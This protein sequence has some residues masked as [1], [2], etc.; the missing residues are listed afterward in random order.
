MDYKTL[1]GNFGNRSYN[2]YY[3]SGI[4][5]TLGK[6]MNHLKLGRSVAIVS[7][8]KLKKV[9]GNQI[10]NILTKSGRK[11]FW[12]LIPSGEKYKNLE[13][14]Q[15]I[16]NE[17][18][19]AK[20]DKSSAVIAFGGGVLQDLVCFAAATYLR[21]V[22][23]VQIPTTLLSQAD[24]GIGGCAVDH[25]AGK[26]LIGTFYQ[27]KLALID[28]DF[29]STLPEHEVKNGISEMINKV[30]CLG[31]NDP[32]SLYKDIPKLITKDKR[33]ILEYIRIAN[34]IKLKIIE[35]DETG[36]LGTRAVLDFGHTLTYALE[37]ATNY[38][39]P[40][41][42]ALGI[43]M[44]AALLLSEQEAG[45]SSK[46]YG[47][48]LSLIEKAGLPTRI[49]S[50]IDLKTLLK[51]MHYD[52]KAKDGKIRFVLL[53]DL[54]KPFVSNGMDDDKITKSLRQLYD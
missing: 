53:R 3:G 34:S 20:I 26:S 38:K 52:Q 27:P 45:F 11:P 4:V 19:K 41:G 12:I 25:P 23:Y 15:C 35:K 22:P 36:S 51:F 49:P 44:R 33:K 40:H 54:G 8:P 31:G 2:F 50:N 6:Q 5:K 37:R 32:S 17:F 14:V 24:I 16:Y 39:L 42:F 43:G 10:S 1:H 28:V 18:A 7:H 21:G 46:K 9:F 13:T 30:I 29:L 47:Q 48:I